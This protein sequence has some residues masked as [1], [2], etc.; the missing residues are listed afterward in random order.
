MD[1]LQ[2]LKFTANYRIFRAYFSIGLRNSNAY[3]RHSQD[4]SQDR[5]R[6]MVND[7]FSRAVVV[8]GRNALI[9]TD[10]EPAFTRPTSVGGMRRGR[11]H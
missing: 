7:P 10:P 4:S 9:P 6:A 2:R 3:L 5:R 1:G 8:D 11:H